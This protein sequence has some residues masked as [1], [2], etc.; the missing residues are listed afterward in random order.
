[1]SDIGV[2]ES[3]VEDA[4]LAWLKSLGWNI[5]HGPNIAPDTTAQSALTMGKYFWCNVCAT[6]SPG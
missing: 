4:A 6:P 2:T 5:A 1:M 3:T